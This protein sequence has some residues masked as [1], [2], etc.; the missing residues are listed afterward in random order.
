MTDLIDDCPAS[1]WYAI[2]DWMFMNKRAT[3]D[4]YGVRY[5][6]MSR[7]HSCLVH[8]EISGRQLSF[9]FAHQPPFNGTTV[10]QSI[11][12]TQHAVVADALTDTGRL[13]FGG[14]SNMTGNSARGSSKRDQ[15]DATH[16]IPFNYSQPMVMSRCFATRF[17]NAN[18]TDHVRFPFLYGVNPS[19]E[20]ND[21]QAG[22]DIHAPFN[23]FISHPDLFYS[24]IS[25]IID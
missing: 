10:P 23:R 21:P 25:H 22:N 4:Q 3:G 14:L 17:T 1:E 13:W 5:G 7:L 24:Q 12:T 15:S 18:R 11:V 16:N 2:R 19:E 6:A 9:E 8:G 20:V